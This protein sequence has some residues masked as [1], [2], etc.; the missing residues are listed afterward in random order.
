MGILVITQNVESTATT[1]TTSAPPPSQFPNHT[2]TIS[3]GSKA[4]CR[5]WAYLR[6]R[7]VTLLARSVPLLGR[8]MHAPCTPYARFFF[9]PYTLCARSLHAP[10]THRARS[11]HACARSVHGSKIFQNIFQNIFKT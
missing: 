6:A 10:D 7:S 8:S 9:A 4:T 11:I 3:W 1:S 5:T 2:P